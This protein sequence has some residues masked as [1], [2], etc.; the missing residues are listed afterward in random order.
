MESMGLS[1]GKEKA[2]AKKKQKKTKADAGP[3]TPP[4]VAA[5]RRSSRL[6]SEHDLDGFRGVRSTLCAAA[7]DALAPGGAAVE[8]M[9]GFRVAETD[10]GALEVGACAGGFEHARYEVALVNGAFLDR[11]EK[12]TTAPVGDT[13]FGQCRE[14]LDGIASRYRD[15]RAVVVPRARAL[16]RE[17][18]GSALVARLRDRE[19]DLLGAA[20]LKATCAHHDR[21]APHCACGGLEVRIFSRARDDGD[22]EAALLA[23]VRGHGRLAGSRAV[24]VALGGDAET[25]RFDARVGGVA[26]FGPKAGDG[27][28]LVAVDGGPRKVWQPRRVAGTSRPWLAVK[29]ARRDAAEEA[30][31]AAAE[32]R[33]AAAAVAPMTPDELRG[34]VLAIP[35]ADAEP[36][37]RDL[38][39]RLEL[40]RAAGSGAA[41]ETNPE[42]YEDEAAA[43]E[44]WA[45]AAR[46]ALARFG[47]ADFRPGQL[48]AVAALRTTARANDVVLVARTG[49]GKTEIAAVA[50]VLAGDRARARRATARR[51]TVVFTPSTAARD[52]FVARI[53]AAGAGAVALLAQGAGGED[54]ARAALAKVVRNIEADPARAP[55][56]GEGLD[57]GAIADMLFL[58][59]QI[60]WRVRDD[61]AGPATPSLF[62]HDLGR[63]A[64]DGWLE[65]VVVDECHH[66][67]DAP[68][69]DGAPC[70]YATLGDVLR[71]IFRGA[72]VPVLGMSGTA[73]ERTVRAF[74]ERFH[75]LR[76][77]PVVLRRDLA[78]RDV[79]LAARVVAG[80][81]AL[82]REE[83][84]AAVVAAGE[85]TL[86]FALLPSET[87]KLAKELGG[88]GGVFAGFY[89]GRG[90]GLAPFVRARDRDDAL[91]GEPGAPRLL[92]AY[93]FRDEGPPET[94]GY[95]LDPAKLPALGVSVVADARDK[96]REA[97]TKTT[98]TKRK[99]GATS[100]HASAAD[101]EAAGFKSVK[102][103]KGASWVLGTAASPRDA[104]RATKDAVLKAWN[105]AAAWL[106]ARG[107]AC[108]LAANKALDESV[109]FQGVK[110]VVHAGCPESLTA[111]HQGISRAGR[112]AGGA[113]AILFAGNT[114]RSNVASVLSHGRDKRGFGSLGGDERD[115][116]LAT[117]A[118]AAAGTTCRHVALER[119][120][121]YDAGARRRAPCGVCDNCE[122][123][124]DAA[125][126]VDATA[127]FERLFREMHGAR[128][129]L[130]DAAYHRAY[131]KALDG[132]SAS[133]A[134]RGVGA[135]LAINPKQKVKPANE[136]RQVLV[137][138][139]YL[140]KKKVDD[141]RY[142]HALGPNAPGREDLAGE[143]VVFEIRGR[144]WRDV[145]ID[146]DAA[147]DAMDGVALGAAVPA[148]P[149]AEA[150]VPAT[151]PLDA[152]PLDAAAAAPAA[153]PAA[154]AAA[155]AA[156]AAEAAPAVPAA[157]AAPAEQP[158][159]QPAAPAEQ[160]AAALAPPG[161]AAA[162]QVVTLV[163]LV[164]FHV[165][166]FVERAEWP[167]ELRYE[168]ALASRA[169]KLDVEDAR[170]VDDLKND[171]Q[172]VAALRLFARETGFIKRAE[173]EDVD[174]ARAALAA[175]RDRGAYYG[176]RAVL[177]RGQPD[178]YAPSPAAPGSNRLERVPRRPTAPRAP[179][180]RRPS[181]AQVPDAHPPR[182]LGQLRRGPAG[183]GPL[184][185]LRELRAP[186]VRPHLQAAHG[187]A[188][189]GAAEAPLLRR[190]RPRARRRRHRRRAGL[191]APEFRRPRV[192]PRRRVFVR[193]RAA[194][195]R[196]RAGPSSSSGRS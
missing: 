80:G 20:L 34:A 167:F 63:L 194:A 72:E 21:A 146:V 79:R 163:D 64:D 97:A 101:W 106:G 82:L 86:V 177:E 69:E 154:D 52:A 117:I 2:T 55:A 24:A 191:P 91:L 159:E 161:G 105:D 130:D 78:R 165:C 50:A 182:P 89:N 48:G 131:R 25:R 189:R 7:A 88:V 100:L 45:A 104:R 84:R 133:A 179:G 125:C 43:R 11:Y 16:L 141:K 93:A 173:T 151:P 158:A 164:G 73:S 10:K 62:A 145:G 126:A 147:D 102:D 85:K 19:G 5:P 111:L 107:R 184:R 46:A 59:P 33:R 118:Y 170:F 149:P 83:V 190:A 39:R 152:A 176:G 110:L 134:A 8:V 115:A 94:A 18:G 168:L 56:A 192:T 90:A 13:A 76:N 23:A 81:A 58:T 67:A 36:R 30:A 150:A 71:E 122:A 41:L 96:E 70:A 120:L 17:G 6:Q 175:A 178:R 3:G 22:G 160:P 26:G 27:D 51:L 47:H 75:R 66:V 162:A 60:L 139:G 113:D 186:R 74:V 157:P 112:D 37:V 42:A 87:E 121:R 116:L 98:K 169:R 153:A 109:D 40:E 188:P 193:A 124:K 140:V 14:C 128:G 35:R 123:A 9:T 129:L 138:L 148:T 172:R 44:P 119:A 95:Y 57:D 174:R 137:N 136:L 132:L 108:A 53:A 195:T 171:A 114:D 31:A 28:R 143:R 135:F 183:E 32:R 29:D 103:E 187:A 127:F 196:A 65:R 54:A 68:G 142:G 180:G 1:V 156:P 92:G 181:Q 166:E 61:A 15:G 38:Q 77:P 185:V 12:G 144:E 155:P 99:K 4:R 49:S